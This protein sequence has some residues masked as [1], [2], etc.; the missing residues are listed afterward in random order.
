MMR[1]VSDL[2]DVNRTCFF[3]T[4]QGAA[5]SPEGSINRF[6]GFAVVVSP[7]WRSQLVMNLGYGQAYVR[8]QHDGEWSSWVM[9]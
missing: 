3:Y 1:E 5:N 9:L 4:A 7:A 8:G 6:A 2:N